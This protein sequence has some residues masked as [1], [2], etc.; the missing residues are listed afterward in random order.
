MDNFEKYYSLDIAYEYEI[1]HFP[2]LL[3][4]G[5]LPFIQVQRE[6]EVWKMGKG[7]TKISQIL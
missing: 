5:I 7:E 2:T 3:I 6:G 4:V 1:N